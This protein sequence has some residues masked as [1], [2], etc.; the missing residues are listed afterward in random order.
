MANGN[1]SRNRGVGVGL[2]L[3][4]VLLV[5]AL[6]FVL[7]NREKAS[8]H[9]L[10]ISASMGVWLVILIALVLGFLIGWGSQYV[11]RRRKRS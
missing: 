4:V 1:S 10:W 3:T 2:I 9:L 5:L 8:I 11:G 7:Q 6:V